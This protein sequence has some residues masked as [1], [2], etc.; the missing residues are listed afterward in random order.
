MSGATW[1]SQN[2][3]TGHRQADAGRQAGNKMLLSLERRGHE[4][5]SGVLS[6]FFVHLEVCF[7]QLATT[8][9]RY[10]LTCFNV[11][12][13]R[14]NFG[15]QANR[16]TLCSSMLLWLERRGQNRR[17]ANFD[18]FPCCKKIEFCLLRNACCRDLIPHIL[19]WGSCF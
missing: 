10:V 17:L 5:R 1:A 8:L 2:G 14:I 15:G 7:L 11:L 4:L 13:V 9:K 19:V 3:Q 12:G 18:A 6:A 16:K